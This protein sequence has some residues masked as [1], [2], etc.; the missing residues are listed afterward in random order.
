M[1]LRIGARQFDSQ[2]TFVRTGRRCGT[3]QL[4]DFQKE[5]VR[6]HMRVAR[7]N[8]MDA[9]SMGTIT[10]PVHFHV[11]H[12]GGIGNVSDADL[13]EQL[14]VLNR[15][16]NPHGI[17]FTKAS[18]DRTDNAVFHQMTMGSPAERN[19][20]TALGRNQASSLNFYTAGLGDSLL[21]WATFPS[22][23]AGDPV[24]DG[25][26]VLF[27]SLPNGS[28]TPYNLGA[29]ATHE[30]GHWLG[31]YHTFEGGCLPPGDEVSDTPFE[32]SPNFGPANPTARYLSDGPRQGSDHELHGLHGRHRH[33]GVHG[34]P[35]HAHQA[36]RRA[37]PAGALE[38]GSTR[39]RHGR[40]RLR[41]RRVLTIALS[42]DRHELVPSRHDHPPGRAGRRNS[43]WRVMASPPP[44]N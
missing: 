42:G 5:R 13:D 28:S 33:D 12:D 9:D 27:S 11:I 20:K 31:L 17:K 24:R 7:A 41:D 40:H 37:V 4:N 43:S 19:A 8:G 3:P 30:V 29:T 1:A 15:D 18:V 22:D 16:Y 35:D 21:G 14:D 34:G 36:A 39:D 38:R 44:A 26:V 10:I 23:F 32:S 6:A 2:E 25:V